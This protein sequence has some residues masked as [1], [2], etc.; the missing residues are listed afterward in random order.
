M[1]TALNSR[2]RASGGAFLHS[3]GARVEKTCLR[4]ASVAEGSIFTPNKARK[5][6][7][8]ANLEFEQ[9]RPSARTRLRS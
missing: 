1:L 6:A 9:P 8:L 7:S 3:Q 4:S 2:S 5:I